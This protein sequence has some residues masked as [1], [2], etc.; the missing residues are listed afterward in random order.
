[1][2]NKLIVLDP[3][4][5]GIPDPG[6]IGQQGTKESA[7]AWKIACSVQEILMYQWGAKVV[8]TKQAAN[9]INSDSLSARWSKANDINADIFVSIHLNGA[10]SAQANGTETYH[11]PDSTGGAKL[12]K[13]IQN[14]LVACLGL[15]NR[16]IKTAHFE[17]LAKSSMTAVL[18]EVCFL[19]NANEEQFIRQ[20]HNIQKA[21][22]AIAQGIVD[23]FHT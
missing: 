1:M 3:G 5:S 16:G 2:L 23:Y 11:Y 4:H 15:P 17:V 7:V 6:V 13:A 18:T 21:A 20:P 10:A 14:Q 8:L 9:D 19:S 22:Q 12:A